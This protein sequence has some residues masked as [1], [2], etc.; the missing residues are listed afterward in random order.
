MYYKIQ[1]TKVINNIGLPIPNQYATPPST[2]LQVVRTL[3]REIGDFELY[4]EN[5]NK[6]WQSSYSIFVYTK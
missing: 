1:T 2:G 5:R 6:P 4:L 3:N